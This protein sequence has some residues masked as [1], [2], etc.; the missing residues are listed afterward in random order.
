LWKANSL[1]LPLDQQ[2]QQESRL[3][4]QS[5]VRGLVE[6]EVPR[7]EEHLSR[8]RWGRT[9]AEVVALSAPAATPAAAAA[10]EGL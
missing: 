5:E 4:E 1:Y 2:Q 10:R 7:L 8:G 3:V 9:S 6:S